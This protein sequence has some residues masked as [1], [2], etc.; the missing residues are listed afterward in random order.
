[1]TRF[2]NGHDMKRISRM[3]IYDDRERR[4]DL[5][6]LEEKFCFVRHAI[7]M[8]IVLGLSYFTSIFNIFERT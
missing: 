7:A 3:F 5:L 1:M 8:S 6:G 4:K 2:E